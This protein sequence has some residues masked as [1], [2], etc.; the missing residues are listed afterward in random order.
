MPLSK[1]TLAIAISL[2]FTSFISFADDVT[3]KNSND[4]IEVI[5]VN[6]DFRQHNLQKTAA[7]LSVLTNKNISERNAQNLEELIA[8]APNVNFSS[9]SQRA[10][11]YQIRGIGE[12]S[13]F[14]EP[15]NPSVGLIIDDIDFSGIGS[16]AS[17]FDVYQT[18]IFRGPQGTR[19]GASAMAGVINITTN[20]PSDEFEGAIQLKAGNYN[21]YGTGIVLSGPASEQ[22]NYRLGVEQ[23]NS[24]GFIK[25]T[26]L[27]RED[28]NNRDELTVRGKLAI[29]ASNELTIDLS[30][31]Y[32]NFDNGYD[33]FSLDNN[34]NT[35]SDQ[36]GF[37][38]QKT[39]AFASKFIYTGIR[40]HDLITTFTYAD[41]E[42]GYGYDEDWAYVGISAPENINNQAFAYWEY[43]STDHYFRSRQTFTVDMRAVSK[44]DNRIFNGSTSWVAGIYYKQDGEDLD[45][46]YTYL[47]NDFSSSFNT[48]TYAAYIQFDSQ[49]NN[50][51]TLTT[52]LRFEQRNADYQNTDLLTTNITDNSV[53]RNITDNMLGGKMVLAYQQN[54]NTLWYGQVNRGY[55]AGGVNTDGSLIDNLRLFSPEYVWNYEAG[56]KVSI[57]NNQ[58]YIRAALFYMDRSDVQ[59][60]SSFITTH[61]DGSSEFTVF[62]DNA[63]SGSN[64]GIEIESAWQVNENIEIY[65]AL[66]FLETQFDHFINAEGADLSGRAQAH[67]P[68]YQINLGVNYQLNNYWLVNVSFDS[69]D[70]FYFSVSHNEKSKKVELFN[71]S[72][73]Y[74]KDNWQVKLWSRNL[75]NRNYATRGFYFGNDPRDGYTAKQYTQLGEP[76]VFGATLDYQF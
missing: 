28:T 76:L 59:A 50:T 70:D 19:F 45:R 74:M 10:R 68:N 2:S 55:K 60:K 56:Y 71:A 54:N 8:I 63:T 35:M 1:T 4:N 12:R 17:T 27:K 11:Y 33:A 18:E 16:I 24:D 64:K 36:P 37:D 43:S 21:S 44:V 65:G 57:L 72:I 6:G 47:T 38:Q 5:T 39:S 30:A 31:F 58:A 7:S 62:I 66:G 49:L 48:K 46:Q 52:G 34:R 51:L 69:K 42:L 32:F 73:T 3:I 14:N 13:Q 75:F 9:G 53:Y 23:Y 40:T 67:A 41:S 20:A 26:F 29:T 22:V 25:N 61:A 15:I